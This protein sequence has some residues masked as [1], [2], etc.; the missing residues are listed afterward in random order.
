MTKKDFELLATTLKE[1]RLAR[2]PTELL[3]IDMV[4]RQIAS[5]LTSTNGRFD[6]DRFLTACGVK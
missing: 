3:A 1:C 4:A 2:K 6:R 5:A